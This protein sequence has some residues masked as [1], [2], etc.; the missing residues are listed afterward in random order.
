MNVHVTALCAAA[1]LFAG[2]HPPAGAA[3]SCG[4]SGTIRGKSGDQFVELKTRI[5]DDGSIVVRAPLAVNPDG[6]PGSYTVGDHGFTYIANGLARWRN[7]ARETCDSACTA[8]FKEAEKAGFAKGTDEFCVFAMTVE[9]M[10]PGAAKVTCKDGEVVGNGKGRL[11]AGEVLPTIGGGTV[12][13]Y[14]STTSLRHLVGGKAVYLNAEALPVAVTPRAELLGRAVWVGGS[15]MT[16][17]FA[18][19]GDAGP[20]FGEGSIA[21]HQLLR[22]GAVTSQS[23]GP[24]AVEKR[25]QDGESGLLP[26]FQSRP[27]GGTAD[28]CRTGYTARTASDVRAYGGIDQSI[29][30]VVLGAAAFERKGSTIQSEVTT[31]SV[32]RLAV[33]AGYTDEKIKQMISCLAK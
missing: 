32:Q 17:T 6:G 26:P 20:A 29:D 5:F 25:C 10:D 7:G 30:F 24:I 11:A 16:G 18:V 1:I 13:G 23:V 28:R 12:Q 21:L 22:R 19:V 9:P 31:D 15:G 8:S 2:I 33:E 3:E 4:K 14:A 27:D